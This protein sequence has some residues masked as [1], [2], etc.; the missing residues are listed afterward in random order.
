M[1]QRSGVLG[2]HLDWLVGSWTHHCATL[3]CRCETFFQLF[4]IRCPVLCFSIL[5]RAC[6]L[7]IS[8][9]RCPSSPVLETSW[10]AAWLLIWRSH[11]VLRILSL[12][13]HGFADPNGLK[14]FPLFIS[15]VAPFIK[16]LIVIMFTFLVT[17]WTWWS[18]RAFCNNPFF[19][20]ILFTLWMQL[21]RLHAQLRIFKGRFPSVVFEW[22]IS[23]RVVESH[24]SSF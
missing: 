3:H 19:W 10:G 18:E 21:E 12:I 23:Q 11:W 15:I 17:I 13:L 22:R 16:I 5:T 6:W 20:F 14:S 4:G 2:D 7:L 9:C 1:R 24:A 8:T